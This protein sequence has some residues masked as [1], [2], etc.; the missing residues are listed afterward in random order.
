MAAVDLSPRAQAK[1]G[2]IREAAERLFLRQGFASTSM[3]AITAEAGVSKQTV[4]SYYPSKEELFIDVLRQL[5]LERPHNQLLLNLDDLVLKDRADLQ[6]VLTEV[7]EGALTTFMRPEYVAMLRVIVTEVP[8]LPAVGELFRMTVPEQAMRHIGV[9]LRHAQER[10]IIAVIDTDAATRLLVGSLL[11]YLLLD[12][13]LTEEPA[14]PPAPERIAA[15][16]QLYMNA[17]A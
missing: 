6:R 3:D 13:L 17:L 7:V 4:Y 5:T 8:H 2:Q 14:H 11:T 12:G 15:I 9:L 10:G 16:I 1:R